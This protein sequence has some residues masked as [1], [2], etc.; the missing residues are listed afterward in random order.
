MA[1]R[2]GGGGG[3]VKRG[4]IRR[5]DIE[6]LQQQQQSLPHH[7]S[8]SKFLSLGGDGAGMGIIKQQRMLECIMPD[9][10]TTRPCPLYL[11]VEL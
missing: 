11:N 4:F 9:T 2:G 6:G 5:V 1:V 10:E 3:G 7:F 8:L